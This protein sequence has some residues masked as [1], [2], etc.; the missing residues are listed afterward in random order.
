[1]ESHK[2]ARG[3]FQL[4]AFGLFVYQ[5]QNSIG[6][7]TSRPIVH[8]TSTT[9]FDE[10]KKPYIYICLDN[11]FNYAQARDLGYSKLTDF[12]MGRLKPSEYSWNGKDGNLSFRNVVDLLFDS[13]YINTM[14]LHSNTGE[15]NDWVK[16]ELQEINISPFGSCLNILPS[17]AETMIASTNR[18]TLILLDPYNANS[19][20]VYGSNF[21][22][23]S[24]GPLHTGFFE[25]LRYAVDLTLDN[26][27]IYEGINCINY[28]RIG[29][30]YTE[31]IEKKMKNALLDWYGCL[32]PWY[33]KHSDLTC[34]DYNVLNIDAKTDANITNQF[35]KFMR[36]KKMDVMNLCSPSCWSMSFKL[37]E[38]AKVANRIESGNVHI[39]INDEIIV[40]TDVYAYDMFNL[41][42]DLG[43][44][45]GLWLGLSVLNIFDT[46]VEFYLTAWS[47]YNH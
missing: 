29:S 3:L 30:T 8:Q 11:Q 14:S 28:A 2:I 42:V 1:M 12:T 18:S 44:S 20:S 38:L 5:L 9:T 15:I 36:G 7:Y 41:V 13:N 33:P 40:N 6:K 34:K 21:A 4:F 10:I 27:D 31:C 45:L 43:S 17:R 25:G 22:M 47:K 35:Y 24:F 19:F 32:P 37:T 23:V 39:R 26:H 16:P 46:L